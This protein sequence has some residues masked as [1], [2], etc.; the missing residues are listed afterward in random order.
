MK[1]LIS[2]ILALSLSLSLLASCAALG[3]KRY[4]VADASEK[5][6]ATYTDYQQDGYA[7]FI[8]K[9]SVFSARLTDAVASGGELDENIAIS[10]ISIY[11]AL[12]LAVECA[13]GDTRDEILSAIGVSYEEVERFTPYLYAFSSRDFK[14]VNPMGKEK[15]LA[16][17]ELSNSFW[18][19]DGITLNTQGVEKLADNYNCDLFKV[20][21]GGSEA[22]RAIGAYIKDKTHGLVDGDVDLSPETI[23]TLIN[24]F[25]LKEVWNSDG[26]DLPM[27]SVEYDFLCA[28][29]ETERER[30]LQGYYYDGKAYDGD[31]YS[32][33]YTNTDHGFSI[34]F[35]LPDEDKALSEVFTAENIY[36]VNSITDWGRVDHEN[37]LIHSTRAIFPEY[38][39]EY[40]EDIANILKD[41]FGIKTIFNPLE[42]DLSGITD[43]PAY[44]S[45]VIHKCSLEVNKRG[46][47]GAAV[48]IMGMC[49]SAGP[50][51]DEYEEVYHDFVVDR[52][53]GFVITDSYGAVLFSGVVNEI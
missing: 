42:S 10:P 8:D 40:D 13:V 44:C 2:L 15:T 38:D 26:D 52:A 31:G 47:E 32:A 22:K 51:I 21:F 37:R 46:I 14:Y 34:K 23:I 30:F 20:D 45:E 49:G 3:Y 24:T 27:T 25:Y 33:F 17:E 16:F 7:E 41:E 28:D 1:R 12:A 9:L 50:P 29:G 18:A 43:M 35:I 48:T 6:K 5:I 11:M 19:D 36:T 53:F 39:A 4:S